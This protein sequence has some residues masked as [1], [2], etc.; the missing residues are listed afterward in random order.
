MFRCGCVPPEWLLGAIT[1]MLKKGDPADPNNYRS[2]T[3]GH[4]L[5]KLYALAINARLTTWL[6][7]RDLRAKGQ[8]GFRLGYSTVDSCFILRALAERYLSR[9]VKLF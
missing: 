5:G 8:A 1:P 2:I 3:V 4:V 7:T 9:G 6:E